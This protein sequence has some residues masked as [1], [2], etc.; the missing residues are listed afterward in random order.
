MFTYQCN[1]GFDKVLN[2][3]GEKNPLQVGTRLPAGLRPCLPL[4]LPLV[5]ATD[6]IVQ[7]GV[8]VAQGCLKNYKPFL[9]LVV[10]Y[11]NTGPPDAVTVGFLNWLFNI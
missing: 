9:F 5:Q 1:S 4:R 11:K 2:L 7:V 10:C 8:L 3:R 6:L